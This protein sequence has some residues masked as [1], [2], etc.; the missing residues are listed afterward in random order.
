MP[1]R[2]EFFVLVGIGP[3]PIHR[4]RGGDGA[5]AANVRPRGVHEDAPEPCVELLRL[6]QPGKAAPCRHECF[7]DDVLRIGRTVH[8]GSGQTE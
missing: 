7:L 1:A 3:M 6:A 4:D 2:C 8:D 5:A